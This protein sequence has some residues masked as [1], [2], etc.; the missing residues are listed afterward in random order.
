MAREASHLAHY[1][2]CARS[3][4]HYVCQSHQSTSGL[5]EDIDESNLMTFSESAQFLHPVFKRLTLFLDFDL[6][7][8]L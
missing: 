5:S 7:L 3:I 6:R 1:H 2:S 8:I 4:R